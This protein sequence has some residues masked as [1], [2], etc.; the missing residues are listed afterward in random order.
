MRT[1]I[2]TV[3][4][5][6]TALTAPSAEP[7]CTELVGKTPAEMLSYLKSDRATLK[8]WCVIDAMFALSGYKDPTAIPILIRLIDFDGTATN[9]PNGWGGGAQRRAR[10]A[11]GPLF[12]FGMTAVPALLGVIASPA[13][14]PDARREAVD[15]VMSIHSQ[16][17]TAGVRVIHR[18]AIKP[19][20]SDANNRWLD[21]RDRAI[22]RCGPNFRAACQNVLGER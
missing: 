16:N 17:V 3:T 15:I 2:L 1:L 20:A 13:S 22:N 18:E 7:P 19:Q 11:H 14:S 21:A 8:T 4:L 6:S 9:H 10:P 12:S 5:L